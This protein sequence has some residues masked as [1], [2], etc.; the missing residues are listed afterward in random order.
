MLRTWIQQ[1][2]KYIPRK[3]EVSVYGYIRNA[4]KLG[5]YTTIPTSIVLLILIYTHYFKPIIQMLIYLRDTNCTRLDL[6]ITENITKLLDDQDYWDPEIINVVTERESLNIYL[7]KCHESL[8]ELIAKRILWIIATVEQQTD[9]NISV[10]MPSKPQRKIFEIMQ[11]WSYSYPVLSS[12][13]NVFANIAGGKDLSIKNELINDGILDILC[14][15]VNKLYL[16]KSYQYSFCAFETLEMTSL[17][18]RNLITDR[19]PQQNN[20]FQ[21]SAIVT[22][23]LSTAY[24][25]NQYYTMIKEFAK[26]DYLKDLLNIIKCTLKNIIYSFFQLIKNNYVMMDSLMLR[27]TDTDI[28][29][30][31]IEL[32]SYS[33][34]KCVRC[35]LIKIFLCITCDPESLHVGTLIDKGFF[36]KIIKIFQSDKRKLKYELSSN[37]RCNMLLILSNVLASDIEHVMFV[38]DN[39]ELLEIIFHHLQNNYENKSVKNHSLSCLNNALANNSHDISL[40][41]FTYNK[42]LL[43]K[44]LFSILDNIIHLECGADVVNEMQCLKDM[45]IYMKV[46]SEFKDFMLKIFKDINI[47]QI[48]KKLGFVKNQQKALCIDQQHLIKLGLKEFSPLITYLININIK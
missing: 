20:Y 3:Y 37:E 30:E 18:L 46:N 23:S 21:F 1:G 22:R 2:R 44:S 19:R 31:C 28:L 7:N 15:Q 11:R 13:M 6:N 38:L 33:E 36:D 42:G 9:S 39:D 45:S 34:S 48:F 47:I 12:A 16:M 24:K 35:Y 10:L 32:L 27:L 17:T 40:L 8:N 14:E 43:I 5:F 25:L 4:E 29:R 26:C 41:L